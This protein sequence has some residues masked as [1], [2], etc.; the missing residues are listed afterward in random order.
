V[1]SS[2]SIIVHNIGADGVFAAGI[3]NSAGNPGDMTITW[4]GVERVIPPG[5]YFRIHSVNPEPNC[6][7]INTAGEVK[8]AV[9]GSYNIKL[10]AMHEGAPDEW[11]YDDEQLV[12]VT[13]AGVT[14]PPW[15]H[16]VPVHLYDNFKLK[17]EAWHIYV[18]DS[19][20]IIDIDT[21]LLVGGKLD[22]TVQYTQG[23][24]LAETAYIAFNDINIVT[25]SLSKGE[26]KSGTI[27]LT[28]L[29][30][31]EAKIGISLES[32]IGFWSEISFDIWLTL[33]FS[34]EPPI[35]PGPA[36]FDWM[37]W[38][39][40]NAWWISLAVLGTGLIIMYRPDPPVVIYQPPGKKGG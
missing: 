25:E 12:T 28:G 8:F 36:P 3:V 27:D 35:P 16:T 34:E 33:G 6:T 5:E 19:R 40:N 4:D 18:K 17:A 9:A 29:I 32:M 22:Y 30:G 37:E 31:R 26:S 10:W 23:S 15:P 38:F 11:F 20:T 13:V 7:R 2:W 24:P 14:P 21:S 39:R 1:Q